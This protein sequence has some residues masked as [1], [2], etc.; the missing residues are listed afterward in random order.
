MEKQNHDYVGNI[1]RVLEMAKKLRKAWSK[2]KVAMRGEV[3]E[4]VYSNY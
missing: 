4:I 3:V 2:V 1:V